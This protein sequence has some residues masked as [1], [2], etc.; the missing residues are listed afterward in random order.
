MITYPNEMV[1]DLF[2]EWNGQEL[3]PYNLY[4]LAGFQNPAHAGLATTHYDNALRPVYFCRNR[5]RLSRPELAGMTAHF[6][7]GF[8]TDI[9][10]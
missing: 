9:H 7:S 8:I 2:F 6:R 3:T 5:A 1:G 10:E 4:F